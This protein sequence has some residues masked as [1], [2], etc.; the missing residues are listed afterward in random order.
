MSRAAD[1]GFAS[2]VIVRHGGFTSTGVIYTTRCLLGIGFHVTPAFSPACHRLI[3]IRPR[4]K[5]KRF[6]NANK[7]RAP[8]PFAVNLLC[9]DVGA[10]DSAV[11][12]LQNGF[13]PCTHMFA[14]VIWLQLQQS[15]SRMRTRRSG[16][17]ILDPLVIVK[18][19]SSS[20]LQSTTHDA[21]LTFVLVGL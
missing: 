6:C 11:R 10:D 7:T 20:N 5:D 9:S 3:C 17:T 1:A 16:E 12:P 19:S 4:W 2:F 21:C 8:V 13:G 14:W 15:R 18:Y